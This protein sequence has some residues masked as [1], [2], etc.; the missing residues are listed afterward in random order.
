[1]TGCERRFFLFSLR[2]ETLAWRF[3]PV[4]DEIDFCFRFVF[5]FVFLLL[6]ALASVVYAAA[7]ARGGVGRQEIRYVRGNQ[8][9]EK[10]K[11]HS[12]GG[13]LAAANHRRRPA[14]E[15]KREENPLRRRERDVIAVA[16]LQKEKKKPGADCVT[17]VLFVCLLSPHGVRGLFFPFFSPAATTGGVRSRRVVVVAVVDAGGTWGAAEVSWGAHPQKFRGT[18]D[19]FS[20]CTQPSREAGDVTW[21]MLVKHARLTNSHAGCESYLAKGAVAAGVRRAETQHNT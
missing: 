21:G 15:E 13:S 20:C 10:K 3:R 12:C 16:G 6:F 4:A 18:R 8:Q 19:G 9:K 7:G 17:D 14:T 11:A 2:G 5:V 1:V